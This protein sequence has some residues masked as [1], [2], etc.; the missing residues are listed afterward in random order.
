MEELLTLDGI[1]SQGGA[2]A[3]LQIVRTVKEK[4]CFIAQDYEATLAEAGS[5]N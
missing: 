5:S 4:T 2:G 3:W 1:A